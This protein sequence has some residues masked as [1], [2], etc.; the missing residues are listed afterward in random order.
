MFKI[1]ERKSK[2]E[3][4]EAEQIRKREEWIKNRDH[5]E[6]MFL[7]YDSLLMLDDLNGGSKNGSKEI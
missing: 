5:H 6:F 7:L 1:F 4:R 3:R 2:E